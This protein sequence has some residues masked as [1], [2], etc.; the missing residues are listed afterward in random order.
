MKGLFKNKS[1][2]QYH[3]LT[4]SVIFILFFISTS[5]IVL[6]SYAASPTEETRKQYFVCE[7]RIFYPKEINC[8]RT[9]S[10]TEGFVINGLSTLIYD[11][12]EVTFV[13]TNSGQALQIDSN[14]D[15]V[16]V[17]DSD[18]LDLRNKLT[19]NL[20]INVKENPSLGIGSIIYKHN[21]Y[22]LRFNT[23]GDTPTISG[24][25]NIDGKAEPRVT[26]PPEE[27]D[28]NKWMM[29]TV[30][31]DAND[32]ENNFKIY[33]NGQLMDETTRKGEISANTNPLAIGGRPSSLEPLG[34]V[35]TTQIDDLRIY[36]K[37]LTEDEIK[38]LF[39]E[40]LNDSVSY[41]FDD[42]QAHWK[43]DGDL[44]DYS[45]HNNNGKQKKS[46][47]PSMVFAPDG[48]M[49]FTEKSTGA[50]KIMKD[51][52]IIKTP[53]VRIDDF[54]NGKEQGLLG[55]TVDPFFEENHYLYLYYTTRDDE[56]GRIFNKLVRFTDSNDSATEMTTLLEKIPANF[57]G[58]HAGGALAFGP[59]DK[60]YVTV[61]DNQ[62]PESAQ[63]P[64]ILTGKI[65]RINRDGTIPSDNPFK[66]DGGPSKE[67]GR[68]VLDENF[69]IENG[70]WNQPVI[71]LSESENIKIEKD[72][73]EKKV[74]PSSLAIKL[75]NSENDV[76]FYRDYTRQSFMTDFG[77][78]FPPVRDW[79]DYKFINFWIKGSN[80]NSSFALKI[81]DT[82]WSDRDE[83]YFIINNFTGWKSFSVSLKE[84]FPTMDFSK[85]R[86][87]EFVFY[88]S[89]DSKINLDSVYLSI[90]ENYLPKEIIHENPSPVYTIGHRNMFG[91]AFNNNEGYGI[92]TENGNVF[93]DEINKIEKGA[94][95]GWPTIQE[96]DEPP[97]FSENS[98][99]PLFSYRYP[100]APAQ[101]IFY[102][103]E[104][105][106]ELTNKFIFTSAKLNH[107]F[108]LQLAKDGKEILKQEVIKGYEPPLI[109]IAQSPD[110]LIYYGGYGIFRL[111]GGDFSNSQ[112]ILFPIEIQGDVEV[113]ELKINVENKEII[114]NI[115]PNKN[116]TSLTIDLP[117]E[118][119][120]GIEI[121]TF[122][123][124]IINSSI[125]S[126]S[127]HNI[128]NITGPFDGPGHLVLSGTKIIPEFSFVFLGIILSFVI[129]LISTLI[130]GMSKKGHKLYYNYV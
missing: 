2:D 92:V 120:D 125:E 70:A 113:N 17:A 102:D 15:H 10:K 54:H 82:D 29:I 103:G 18:S 100:I 39:N 61:G 116:S 46:L 72:H 9:M 123:N 112:Q 93:F 105:I 104:K 13:K 11:P 34:F 50:V 42:I 87:F 114:L 83:Q 8:D 96:P 63:D 97:E 6:Y 16:L 108:A 128:I 71:Q 40:Q 36:S 94:N 32:S 75:N 74:G 117:K 118:I 7:N 12:S 19:I 78:K 124:E 56:T 48:R 30:T 109:S 21:A 27:L 58:N 126:I 31:Y 52:K 60:L 89:W 44:L 68:E 79:S 86:G 49:F 73:L 85:V 37:A 4:F 24:F 3:Y 57:L 65:L 59:D 26:L 28:I 90:D 62:Y 129:V 45:G 14:I 122:N 127:N 23:Q 1:K 88:K 98:T 35:T 99:K 119:I 64:T 110:G 66:W 53:F 76:S 107:L 106:P 55:I 130:L 25:V 111:D 91:I 69:F 77:E 41:F 43:F 121:I 67:Y 80:T 47:I 20:W 101:L 22:L 84:T 115:L 81:K 33:K 51:E 95:Y 5:G 38:K